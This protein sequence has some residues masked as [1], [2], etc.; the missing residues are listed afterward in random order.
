MAA[1]RTPPPVQP[2]VQAPAPQAPPAQAAPG[3]LVMVRLSSIRPSPS[4]PRKSFPEDKLQELAASI[5]QKGV[6]QPV[7][8]RPHPENGAREAYELVAGERR[9]RAAGLAGLQVVPA[10]VRHLSAVA[11]PVLRNVQPRRLQPGLV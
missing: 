10:I 8:L 2:E 11:A 1:R 3:E 9:V 5:R 7:L 6:L 4:N